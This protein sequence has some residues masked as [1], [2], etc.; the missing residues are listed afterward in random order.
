MTRQR[1]VRAPGSES[2]PAPAGRWLLLLLQLPT[3]PSRAR[4]QT[5]RRLQ[6][7]G[8][9]SLKNAAYLLPNTPQ[10]RED[11]EWMKREIVGFKGQASVF[12]ADAIGEAEDEAIVAAFRDARRQEFDEVIRSL[13]RLRR[14][15]G[16]EAA[17]R[18]T[19]SAL[20]AA[21][22]TR[23]WRQRLDQ[24]QD[25]DFFEAPNA[26][27]ARALLQDIETRLEGR[28]RQP[29]K[30]GKRP[31]GVY[32]RR[33]WVTRPR[34]G[35]DRMGSAWLIRR[36]IDPE[37]RFE[38]AREVPSAD[39][40]RVPFDMFDAEFSHHGDSCTFEVL[41]ERF[42]ID[43]PAVRHIGHIVH[44]LDLKDAKFGVSE[45]STIGGL[46]EGLGETYGD[47][48]ELLEHGVVL[49][50]GLYRSLSQR[51]GETTSRPSRSPQSSPRTQRKH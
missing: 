5:W 29:S 30:P 22:V 41:V 20:R 27:R 9:L 26:A 10:A 2:E 1:K 15:L 11:F 45:A 32:R 34:P 46:V 28:P 6:R 16:S 37:A 25:V 13:E 40:G 50:E 24:I 14:S 3:R 51:A 49:F 43:D 18:G 4:V 19:A 7:L 12:A 39:S 38:F 35:I 44:D 21:R 8:A 42:G 23:R 47:D 33:T 17:R 31:E 48:A 36:F